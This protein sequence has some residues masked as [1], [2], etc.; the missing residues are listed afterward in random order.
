MNDTSPRTRDLGRD[1]WLVLLGGRVVD[2]R[3]R[4]TGGWL[5]LFPADEE[6]AR[7]PSRVRHAV[8]RTDGTYFFKLKLNTRRVREADN[9]LLL[10]RRPGVPVFDV[11]RGC[12]RRTPDAILFRAEVRIDAAAAAVD[13]RRQKS[14]F[15]IVIEPP[16]AAA[17]INDSS[18]AF[19]PKEAT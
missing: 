11:E 2:P 18:A 4:L 15:D 6:Q 10:A 3:R 14:A 1:V 9:Y 13:L 7:V 8:L 17:S 12:Y 5:E 16:R 19:E